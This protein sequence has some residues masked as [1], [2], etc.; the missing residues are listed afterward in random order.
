M[1]RHSPGLK[2]TLATMFVT[3][4]ALLTPSLRAQV[5]T[6]MLSGT[7]TD[8]TGSAV[9]NASMLLESTERKFVREAT[10]DGLGHYTFTAVPP[11]SYQLLAKAPGFRDERITEVLLSSGQASTLNVA[12]KLGAAVEQITITEAP[13]LL[14]TSNATVGATVESKQ[15]SELPILGRNFTRALLIAPGVSAVDSSDTYNRS[16]AGLAVNPSFYGQRQRNNNF[17][18]DGVGNKDSLFQHINLSP[19]LEAIAEMKIESG[20]STGAYGHASGANVNV[21]TK[22]GTRELHADLWE[23]HRNNAINAAGFFAPMFDRNRDRRLGPYKWNQFGGAVGGPLVIPKLVSK[24]RNWYF[25]TYYEGIRI[26]QT[27][28]ATALVPTAAQLQG[29]FSGGL[30]IYD[31]YTTTAGPAGTPVRQAFPENR[32][33]ANLLNRPALNIMRALLPLPNFPTGVLPGVNWVAPTAGLR[34]NSDQ[35]SGRVDHQFGTKNNFYL[36]Y[37]DARVDQQSVTFPAL[38]NNR[39]DRN[40]NIVLSNTYVVNPRLLV[41]G[42]FGLTR[43]DQNIITRPIPGLARDNGTLT[44][45]E[46]FRG[47][48]VIPPVTIIGYPGLSQGVSIYGPQYESSWIADAQKIQGRHTIDFGGSIIRTTFV[49]DNQSGRQVIFTSAQT[50]NFAPNTGASLASFVLGLPESAA[51]IFG[52]TEGDMSGNAYSLY[53]Q[54]TLRATPRLTFNLG[55]RYDYASPMINKV[56]SG[57]FIFETGKYVWDRP[58]PITGEG[59]NIRRGAIDP[60]K[61][62]IQP[63]IGL[64]YQASQKTVIRSSFGVFFDTFGVNYAQTQQGNRGAYPFTFP[65]AATGLNATTPNAF[66]P[67]PF[68]GPP[69][70]TRTPNNCGSQCLNVFHDTTRVPYVFQ[71]TFSI[72][73][74]L[75]SSLMTEAVYFGSHGVKISGQLLDNTAAA[76]GPGGISLRRKNP[77]F[78]SYIG[79]GFNGYHSYYE[80]MSVKLDKRFSRGLLVQANYTW[81][82]TMNQSDSLASGGGA[83]GQPWS[84]PTR[85]NL[86]QFRARAGY[87]IPHRL[88]ISG[89]YETPFK[90]SSRV[91]NAFLANWAFSTIAS[92]DSGLPYTVFLASDNENIGPPGGRYTQFPNLV[93]DPNGGVQRGVF[94]W[95]NTDAFKLP[96]P[97]TAGNSGRNTLRADG[98]ANVD[99]SAYK[100]FP[101]YESRYVE[102]RGEF[103]NSSNTTTFTTPN[104]LL[105]T[106]Q[107]GTVTGTRNSGRQV[108]LAVRLRF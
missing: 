6:A 39:A 49:T 24:E 64:A 29:D 31:P 38:P 79:N 2:H 4:V 94:R 53:V 15:V 68:P 14:Q 69:I 8:P 83:V 62:N 7:V 32:I 41:T 72:Q 88:V 12:M 97:Y 37:S 95:F 9:P 36:R 19:P 54:D 76:P 46:P 58:N 80:G 103:F 87:D 66:F 23:Y 78:E 74:Q 61:N 28:N 34:N 26:R 21:V 10:A 5:G 82:K 1:Q 92:F 50:S 35:W 59:P 11:G 17:T 57:T 101:I 104:S 108:Q 27:S 51:R 60:D 25:F 70:G 30:P 84:N 42:R 33:P 90:T 81:S 75:T 20:M 107:F 56:G 100:R 77:Q 16:V 91:A 13:P 47:L 65:Q 96:P 45:Y 102:L 40:S 98:F 22:S 3:G 89:I 43:M 86:R 67:N 106:P 105:G 71:W 93:G 55:L 73:R 18:L 99:F 48:E 85:Y 63:R 52:S 44:A